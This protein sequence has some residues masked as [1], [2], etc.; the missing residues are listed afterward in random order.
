MSGDD[1][2][3]PDGFIVERNHELLTSTLFVVLSSI[4]Q[5]HCLSKTK[6]SGFPRQN[7]NWFQ[8]TQ[9]LPT[10]S[11]TFQPERSTSYP[12]VFTRPSQS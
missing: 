6:M 10:E 3:D 5:L 12:G 1:R 2:V 8:V 11:G 4:F 7:Q 9:S